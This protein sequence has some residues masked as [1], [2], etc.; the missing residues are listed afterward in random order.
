MRRL[1]CNERACIYFLDCRGKKVPC[2]KVIVGK[3]G[4]SSNLPGTGSRL[5]SLFL[6][7]FSLPQKLG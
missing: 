2:F 3:R 1:H 4:G 5:L 6:L 7:G